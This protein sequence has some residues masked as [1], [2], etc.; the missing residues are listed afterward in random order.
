MGLCRG[1]VRFFEGKLSEAGLLQKS[2][3]KE[4]DDLE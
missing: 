1:A 2:C 3:D 4:F